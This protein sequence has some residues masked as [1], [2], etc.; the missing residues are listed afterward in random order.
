VGIPSAP[1][2]VPQ[3]EV[4]FDIDANGILHVTAKDLGTGKQQD[5]TI[6]ASSGLGK[7]EVEQM[8]KD[9]D[10]HADEDRKRREEV[11]ARNRADSMIYNTE[12]LLRENREKISPEDAQEIEAAL[13]EAKQAVDSGKSAAEIDAAVEK[14][15]KSTHRM[16]EAMY[17]QAQGAG[18]QGGSGPGSGSGAAS[19]GAAEEK[20][21][22][23]VID[24]EYVDV[25][26]DKERE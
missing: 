14:L 25:D 10:S 7:D 9:A 4:T 22:G 20:K 6:T 21:E 1:R 18:P 3:I 8:Q 13:A 2:G 17:Q 24:A 5:I 12:R 16:A 15:T 26:E 11:E 23:E 19:G